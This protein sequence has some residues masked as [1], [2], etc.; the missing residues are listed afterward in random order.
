[1][2]SYFRSLARWLTLISLA[3]LCMASGTASAQKIPPSAY[4]AMRWR[5]IGPFRGG[6]A[7]AVAGVPGN[8]TLFYFGAVD[9]GVWKTT[10]AGRVWRPLWTHEAIASIGSIAVADSDPNVIYAGTGEAD[11]RSDLSLGGGMYKSTDAGKTWRAVGL[12]D[13]LQISK[14]IVDP[15]NADVILVAALGHAYGPNPERGVFRSTD[16]GQT[17]KKVLYK[18]ENTGAIDIC[19]DP[20][21]SQVVYAALYNAHRVPWSTY[22]PVEGPGSGIYK[23]TDGGVTWSEITGHGLPPGDQMGRIGLATGYGAAHARVYALIEARNGAGK[24]GGLYRSADGGSSW[25]RVSTD[26]R[27]TERGWY[28]GNIIVD[29]SNADTVFVPDVSLYRSNDGGKHFVAYKGAPGGDDY[30]ALW[31]DP[32]NSNRMVLGCDQGTV[33]TL[34][35]GKTWSSWYNQATAQI[36]HV[37]TDNHFPYRVYG[38]QQD[39]GSVATL[40][41]GND[42]LISVREWH[43]VGGGESGY[44]APD[45]ADPSIVYGGDTYGMVHRFDRRTGQVQDVSPYPFIRSLAPGADIANSKLRFTWT[46]PLVFSLQNPHILYFGAQFLLKTTNGGKDWQRISPDLTLAPDSKPGARQRGVIYTIAPSPVR[47]GE[48]WVGT[49]NGRVQLTLDG[50]KSWKDVTPPTLAPWSKI[51]LIE[52]SRFDAGTAYAAVDRHRVGDLAPY[53][54][55][56]HDFGATWT[57]VTHGIEAP[58][59]IHAV[60]EDP[61][62]K[63]LLYAGTETGVYVSFDDGGEW[64]LLQLNLP[65]SSIRDLAIHDND[66]IV[67]THGRSFWILDD[68]TPLRQLDQQVINSD[69]HLFRPATAIR[70]RRD[71]NEDT[72]LPPETPAGQNPPSG[73]IIDYYLKTIPAG[74]VTLEILDSQGSMVRRYESGTAPAPDQK[75]L[76][77]PRYWLR[78]PAPLTKNAGM[79]RFV[80]DLRYPTPPAITPSYT[81][82]AVAGE[83]TPALPLG[84]LALPGE[85]TVRLMVGGHQYDQPLLVKMDPRV[86]TPQSDLSQE[87]QLGLK[88]SNDLKSEHGAHSEITRME[89][90]LKSLKASVARRNNSLAA[91]IEE[92]DRNVQGIDKGSRNEQRQGLAQLDDQLVTLSGVVGAADA[93]PTNQARQ[94]FDQCHATLETLLTKWEQIQRSAIPKLETDLKKAGISP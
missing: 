67:A 49:D 4:Q 18:D 53:I 47:S 80:W 23:S 86:T 42:G 21:N 36:Y 51:S 31:I 15:A 33:I 22:A 1:M 94:A 73:A 69:V 59:Y 81:M 5:L 83:N 39:S 43:P 8:P 28:F 89:S 82:H 41:R 26:P 63:G 10:D 52:A 24:D 65:T 14:V 88:I 92:A 93:A 3:G 25:Q 20:A 6:R 87:L 85:Y 46:S 2:A 12:Q 19:F 48:I 50:G 68:L 57:E 27:I 44:I 34:D 9:G 71:V 90:K 84:P 58:A 70:I 62:Q 29:P 64:E 30:H 54:Y 76:E 17:W 74:Q 61:V 35:G 55:R 72:P 78:P 45:P 56:T 7:I 75:L 66:L 91:E 32:K 60:R 37:T 11:I 13:T 38:A 79:N 16:G 77:F 40:S